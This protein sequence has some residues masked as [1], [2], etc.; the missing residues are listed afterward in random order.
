MR[1]KRLKIK[2]FGLSLGL[3]LSLF[4]SAFSACICEHHQ[5]KAATT[6]DAASCHSHTPETGEEQTSGVVAAEDST[7]TLNPTISG[8][9]CCCVQ[10]ATPKVFAKSETVKSEKHTAALPAINPTPIVFAAR[11]YSLEN[12]LPKPLY[13]TD[14]FYNLTPGRAPPRL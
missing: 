1:R 5:A 4:V 9:N 11:I 12:D 2:Q 14:S 6:A 10:P 13:L 7:Q 3:M 8:G